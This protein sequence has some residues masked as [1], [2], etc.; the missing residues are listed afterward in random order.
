MGRGWLTRC[1]WVSRNRGLIALCIYGGQ[2][3][4]MRGQLDEMSGSSRPWVGL[5]GS[6]HVTVELTKNSPIKI[7]LEIQNV[8]KTAPWM[9]LV[10]ILLQTT[11]STTRCRA[12]MV[13]LEV[14]PVQ[15]SR[16]CQRPSQGSSFQPTDQ[17]IA[18]LP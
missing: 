16:S 3:R 13:I 15:P 18:A 2:L 12:L 11:P 8:G 14:M 9:R 10:S 4:V 7:R 17:A 1:E 6:E 5:R